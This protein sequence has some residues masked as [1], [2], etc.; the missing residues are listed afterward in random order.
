MDPLYI[1]S[2]MIH[3]DKVSKN[4][5]IRKIKSLKG[6]ESIAFQSPVTF[7]VGEN[8]SGK[9][10]LLEAMA[11]SYGFNPEGGTMNYDFSTF[12][13][14]SELHEAVTLIKGYRRAKWSYFLRA[15]SFYN[16]A[17]KEDEYSRMP[18]GK[19]QFFHEKS[20]GESFFSVIQ[21]NFDKNGLFFLDE[22]EAALS[23]QR[24]LSLLIELYRCAKEGSQFFIVTHSPILLGLPD[25]QILTFDKGQVHPC[26]YEETDSY[27]ITKSFINN[28]DGMLKVMLEE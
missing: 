15:E 14:H 10:T 20:H 16:V 4:S 8:G 24:Q 21:N 2:M 19:P 9:S 1:K 11:V 18:G 12:D 6:L 5:Y 3:W 7:F 17:T 26:R 28:R 25:A 13:S 27:Q 23:P 22:P